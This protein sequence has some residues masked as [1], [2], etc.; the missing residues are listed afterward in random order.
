MWKDDRP[1]GWEDTKVRRSWGKLT[2][3]GEYEAGADAMLDSLRFKGLVYTDGEWVKLALD[4]GMD[5]DMK[6]NGILTFIPE[7]K[8]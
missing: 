4:T 6:L 5:K 7:E 2:L 1:E 8:E 3:E